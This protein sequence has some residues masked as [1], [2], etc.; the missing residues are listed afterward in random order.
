V[1]GGTDPDNDCSADSPASCGMTGVCSGSGSC[2][3]YPPPTVCA[4]AFCSGASTS[5]AQ[6]NCNGFGTCIA[7]GTTDCT[8][9][10]CNGITGSCGSNCT[11]DAGCATGNYCSANV[12]ISKKANGVLC[13]AGNQCNSGSCTDGVCCNTACAGQC[14]A[15]TAV[16]KGSGLDGTCG[17]IAAGADPDNECAGTSTCN[18]AGGCQ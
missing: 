3:L 18:G 11:N 2:A 1:A 12:C 5:T 9:Y 16:K 6:S 14:Q 7:G 10:V 15:C 17:N 4:A 13:A 8:P